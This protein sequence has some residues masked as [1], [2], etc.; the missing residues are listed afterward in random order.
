ML[1]W[2]ASE[3]KI[4]FKQIKIPPAW[5]KMPHFRRVSNV[6]MRVDWR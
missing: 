4:R 3:S 6:E 1:L 2:Y 5:D